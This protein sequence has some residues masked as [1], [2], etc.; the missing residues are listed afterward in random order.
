MVMRCTVPSVA[1]Y[2]QRSTLDGTA[3]FKSQMK[4]WREQLIGYDFLDP[5]DN[6]YYHVVEVE[7]NMSAFV[8]RKRR[9]LAYSCCVA[10]LACHNDH[11]IDEEPQ[12]IQQS[13]TSSEVR[14]QFCHPFLP[15]DVSGFLRVDLST[16]PAGTIVVNRPKRK[17]RKMLEMLDESGLDLETY[18]FKK[19]DRSKLTASQDNCYDNEAIAVKI[20]GL[21]SFESIAD[22][23]S[24][25]GMALY[26]IKELLLETNEAAKDF[27]AR[28]MKALDFP[29][30]NFEDLR[31]LFLNEEPFKLSSD[32]DR[33]Q[34]LAF[35]KKQKKKLLEFGVK[36]WLEIFSS[37]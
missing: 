6:L 23:M 21:Y 18:V 30:Y 1:S 22:D 17:L 35:T 28:L 34:V 24:I 3:I 31:N 11:E 33:N 9:S 2:D 10:W 13:K 25:Y 15:D 37:N 5:E 36:R 8:D 14:E 16:L 29:T 20:R 12:L 32:E 26:G 19:R 4:I 27:H 7:H